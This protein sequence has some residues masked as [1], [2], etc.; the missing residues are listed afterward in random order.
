MLVTQRRNSS[1]MSRHGMQKADPN[2]KM[3][4]FGPQVFDAI[5]LGVAPAGVI[6]NFEHPT[7]HGQGCVVASSFSLAIMLF[8][9]VVRIYDRC[10]IM[11]R[12]TSDDTIFVVSFVCF[13]P[14][15]WDRRTTDLLLR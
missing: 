1:T 3:Q 15:G 9:A 4:Y 13:P 14:Y 6:P 10:C 11:Q 8:M 12:W 2:V 7:W 5:V